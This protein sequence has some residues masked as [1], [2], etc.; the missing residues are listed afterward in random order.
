MP[1]RDEAEA[2]LT[3]MIAM[4]GAGRPSENA[5][6]WNSVVQPVLSGAFSDRAR[7]MA[8]AYATRNNTVGGA[9]RAAV[10]GYGSALNAARAQT[11]SEWLRRYQ[12]DETRSAGSGNRTAPRLAADTA[13]PPAPP[14]AP[15]QND[16]MWAW[17]D[18][19]LNRPPAPAPPSARPVSS[20]APVYDSSR[21]ATGRP[22]RQPTSPRRWS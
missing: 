14:A 1:A 17:V 19:W 9:Q 15:A 10:G 11:E 21:P 20:A 18:E 3:Q 6:R 13:P 12:A 16:N 2:A 7:R 5:D 22:R 8:D 4:R